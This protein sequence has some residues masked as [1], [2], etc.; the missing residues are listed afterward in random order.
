[1]AAAS[2]FCRS[3]L[4]DTLTKRPTCTASSSEAAL[5]VLATARLNWQLR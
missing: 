4:Q 5:C 3:A 1:L 2:A